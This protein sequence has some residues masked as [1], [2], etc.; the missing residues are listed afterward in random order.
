MPWFVSVKWTV[1]PSVIRKVGA[2]TW[3]S[4]FIDPYG[5]SG[6]RAMRIVWLG[7]SWDVRLN[8]TG[9]ESAARYGAGTAKSAGLGSCAVTEPDGDGIVLASADG[10]A[11][12]VEAVD[13]E[14]ATG[15]LGVAAPAAAEAAG[16]NVQPAAPFCPQPARKAAAP[17]LP[18]TKPARRRTA[19]RLT[20]IGD[21]LVSGWMF[22]AVVWDITSPF[23]RSQEPAMRELDW[24]SSAHQLVQ[25]AQQLAERHV[26]V[27]HEGRDE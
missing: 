3:P 11:A 2:G 7:P 6:E 10:L 15:R 4:K 5:L 18:A 8:S 24:P 20:R 26:R 12:A 27:G 1:S 14:L 13:P 17:T 22:A 16:P 21:S 23:H 9:V 19:R 25:T